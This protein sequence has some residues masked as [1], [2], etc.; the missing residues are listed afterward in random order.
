LFFIGFVVFPVW[1][2]TWFIGVPQTRRLVDD[3]AE[4]GIPG[5]EKAV[6]LDD[7]QLEYGKSICD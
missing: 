4:M 1:W 6:V 3:A 2:V 7:P 5:R